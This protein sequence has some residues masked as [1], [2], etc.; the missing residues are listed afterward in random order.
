M[1]Y[2]IITYAI[3]SVVFMHMSQFYVN[4]ENKVIFLNH[5]RTM[6]YDLYIK[7]YA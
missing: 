5:Q 4:C 6:T 7:F 2:Y 3:Y 1:I